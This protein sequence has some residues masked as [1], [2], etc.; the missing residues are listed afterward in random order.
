MKEDLTVYKEGM[1]IDLNDTFDFE[2]KQCSA[3]FHYF[4]SDL[5]TAGFISRVC[6]RE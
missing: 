4:D 1:H 3:G 5:H 2:P 6:I